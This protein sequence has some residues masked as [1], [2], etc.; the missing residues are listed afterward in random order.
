MSSLRPQ[1]CC[2]VG[3]LII[4]CDY[5]TH[6]ISGDTA[7]AQRR[8]LT[9]WTVTVAP[10][11]SA[12]GQKNYFS[13]WPSH[14]HAPHLHEVKHTVKWAVSNFSWTLINN[15]TLNHV[16]ELS[17]KPDLRPIGEARRERLQERGSAEPKEDEGS[18]RNPDKERG[19]TVQIRAKEREDA[20]VVA[21]QGRS[22]VW[23]PVKPKHI[24]LCDVS[25]ALKT[26]TPL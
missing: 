3:L 23:T 18:G 19:Q 22:C 5:E 12:S 25:K 8:G 4:N 11:M 21:T 2:T 20:K 10:A 15:V 6:S 26:F 24:S 13:C 16:L 9:D 7:I 1:R 17:A 14:R